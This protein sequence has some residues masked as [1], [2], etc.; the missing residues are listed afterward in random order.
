MV[1]AICVLFKPILFFVE[2]ESV[3]VTVCYFIGQNCQVGNV[4]AATFT[5]YIHRHL[6]TLIHRHVAD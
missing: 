6:Q 1:C 2:K 4:V 3:C 5:V